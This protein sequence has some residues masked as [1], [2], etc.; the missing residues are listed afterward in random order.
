MAGA[1][2]PALGHISGGSV[3]GAAQTRPPAWGASPK[4]CQKNSPMQ[5]ATPGCAEPGAPT[6][7]R[8]GGRGGA[9]GGTE[10]PLGTGRRGGNTV[11]SR[12]RDLRRQRRRRAMGKRGCRKEERR[13]EE[14]AVAYRVRIFSPSGKRSTQAPPRRTLGPPTRR[15]RLPSCHPASPV[16][17]QQHPP[18]PVLVPGT[19]RAAP[20]CR[21]PPRPQGWHRGEQTPSAGAGA[22]RSS[23]CHQHLPGCVLQS[24]PATS[25]ARG[26]W[27]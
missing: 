21:H 14:T 1:E 7:P 3:G 11:K 9:A 12:G 22:L 16:R 4:S 25:R 19:V 24:K 8:R 10:L 23:P 18:G 26:G 20:C 5:T 27:G 6:S 13:G 15:L 17:C 2:P